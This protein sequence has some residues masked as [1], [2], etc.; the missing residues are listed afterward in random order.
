MISEEEVRAAYT[1]FRLLRDATSQQVVKDFLRSKNL[2]VSAANWEELYRQRI[3]PPLVEGKVTVADLRNL[4]RDV[5]ECGRQHVFLYQTAPE[6][7]KTLIDERR[8]RAVAGEAGLLD[9]LDQSIELELPE[10]PTVV[11]IRLVPPSTREPLASLL[12]KQVET[13]VTKRFL[14]DTTDL[15]AKTYSRI[16]SVETKRAVNIARLY[17]NGLLELRITRQDNSTRYKDNVEALFRAIS[18]LITHAGFSEVSL[19]NAKNKL[20]NDRD[21]LADQVRYSYSTAKNDFGFSMNVSCSSQDDSICDDGGSI[22]AL[23]TFIENDGEVTGSNI[24]LKILDSDPVKEIHTL[25]SGEINEFAVPVACSL[26]EYEYVRRKIL[27][28]NV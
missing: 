26:D 3:E 11:D 13:R 10:Q 16:Y 6:Y 15:G 5:E 25:I 18:P 2:P 27:T 7:A 9:R 12:I 20:F 28:L 19:K 21:E 24:Y 4:L 22:A 23:E 1:I 14:R 17:E 8:V